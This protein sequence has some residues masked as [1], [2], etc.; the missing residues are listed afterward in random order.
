MD[1]YTQVA[2]PIQSMNRGAIARATTTSQPVADPKNYLQWRNH[3]QPKGKI[4][5]L[6]YA[7]VL[8]G[9]GTVWTGKYHP[10]PLAPLKWSL[11]VRPMSRNHDSHLR[12][13]RESGVWPLPGSWRRNSGWKPTL[14]PKP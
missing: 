1:D 6:R 12:E 13:T 8:D 3:P 10:Q 7:I 9:G 11:S 14:H 2:P 5:N 4:E